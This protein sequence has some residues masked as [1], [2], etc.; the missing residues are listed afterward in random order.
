MEHWHPNPDFFFLPGAGPVLDVG[1][2]YVADLINLIGPVKRVAAVAN[3]ATPDPHHLDRRPAPGAR[4]S[5]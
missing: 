2:Y 4:R 3:S 5:R 1:P